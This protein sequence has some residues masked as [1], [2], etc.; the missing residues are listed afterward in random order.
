LDVDFNSPSYDG[1]KQAT[2]GLQVRDLAVNLAENF[3]PITNHSSFTFN[4]LPLPPT[5]TGGGAVGGGGGNSNLG[6]SYKASSHPPHLIPVQPANISQAPA[7][8]VLNPPE[9]E[10][11][12]APPQPPRLKQTSSCSSTDAAMLWPSFLLIC[13]WRRLRRPPTINHLKN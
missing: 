7:D 2:I 5:N 4:L 11:V 8:P 12:S 13:F 1:G 9:I 6:S 3:I 10:T